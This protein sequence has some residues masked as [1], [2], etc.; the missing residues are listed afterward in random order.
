MHVITR[1]TPPEVLLVRSK[2]SLVAVLVTR[3]ILL[4]SVVVVNIRE[5]V[6]IKHYIEILLSLGLMIVALCTKNNMDTG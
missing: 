1:G 4:N 2:A 6:N 5:M 3:E